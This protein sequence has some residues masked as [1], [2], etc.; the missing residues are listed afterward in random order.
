MAMVR[1]GAN[2]AMGAPSL[3]AYLTSDGPGE[4]AAVFNPQFSALAL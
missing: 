3:G 1:F 4:G 2:V